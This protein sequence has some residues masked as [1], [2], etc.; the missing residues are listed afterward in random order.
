MSLWLKHCS[1]KNNFCFDISQQN[2]A[3]KWKMIP[4]FQKQKK[5]ICS[6]LSSFL[7]SPFWQVFLIPRCFLLQR[8]Q[9]Q[10]VKALERWKDVFNTCSNLT[11]GGLIAFCVT[12][13][14]LDLSAQELTLSGS[15]KNQNFS[16]VAYVTKSCEQ[17]STF[18]HIS[19]C[20]TAWKDSNWYNL[21]DAS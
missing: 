19:I 2:L 5:F 10:N 11:M 7:V 21:T 9:S 15:T 14:I 4:A 3:K 16:N 8:M 1:Y 12:R 17:N 20:H 13:F 6:N 18:A